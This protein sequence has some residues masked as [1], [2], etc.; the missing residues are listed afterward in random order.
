MYFRTVIC[1]FGNTQFSF[2][3]A[4]VFSLLYHRHRSN[5]ILIKVFVF[6]YISATHVD[7]GHV[8][9]AQQF[10]NL[11]LFHEIQREVIQTLLLTLI[12][13]FSYF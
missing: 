4:H 6:A 11:Q 7:G 12:P 8:H 3:A 13:C 2:R 5:I 1:T 10:I 9:A